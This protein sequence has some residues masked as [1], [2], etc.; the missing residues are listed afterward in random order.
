M[1][2]YDEFWNAL[3]RMTYQNAVQLGQE[4]ANVLQDRDW[5]LLDENGEEQGGVD[6]ADLLTGMALGWADEQEMED[7]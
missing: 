4:I 3:N 7:A 2:P 5:K 1:E 6:I